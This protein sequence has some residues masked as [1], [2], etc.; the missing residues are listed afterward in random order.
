MV[1]TAVKF[2]IS[3]QPH[4]IDPLLKSYIGERSPHPSSH[5]VPHTA[6]DLG[7]IDVPSLAKGSQ[8]PKG[9][10]IPVM[11]IR[12]LG[13]IPSTLPHSHFW[14]AELGAVLSLLRGAP[15]TL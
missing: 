7:L 14:G 8:R 9:H 5:P 15:Q 12:A 4:P 1:I 13:S 3:D 2:L 6:L 11:D 10:F